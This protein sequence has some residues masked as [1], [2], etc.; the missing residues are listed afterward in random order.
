MGAYG[1]PHTQQTQY[2]QQTAHQ[3][4]GQ[5]QYGQQGQQQT[6]N[7]VTGALGAMKNI[8]KI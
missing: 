5:T 6:G 4:Y 7:V 3:P 2:G 1:Q 8:F